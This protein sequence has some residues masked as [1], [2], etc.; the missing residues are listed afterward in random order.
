LPVDDGGFLL[1]GTAGGFY[2][3][4]FIDYQ[5][6]DAEILLIKVNSDGEEEWRQFYGGALHDMAYE[7]RKTNDGYYLI[8]STQS[9]GAGSFDM[10]LIKTNLAGEEEWIKAYGGEEF[11]YGI[12]LDVAPDGNLYLLG[13]TKSFGQS[14]SPD[15]YLIKA[16]SGGNEIWSQVIG[17]DDSDYGYSVKATPDNGCAL[18]GSTK[19]YGS[20]G[21]DVYFVKLDQSGNVEFFTNSTD[22][23]F[24]DFHV[25]F[26]PNPF[27]KNAY[28]EISPFDTGQGF[29]LSIIDSVGNLILEELPINS[30]KTKID[31]KNLS[32][33]MYF[34]IIT[35]KDDQLQPIKGKFVVN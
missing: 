21:K 22:T 11:E 23:V 4:T 34:Y 15:I 10:C 26:Y 33:G 13:T 27:D 12:S 20:G 19:S 31:A 2:N 29:R 32:S 24:S 16:D 9:Y 25:S 1:L 3:I 14:G 5:N 28:I 30:Y 17:G 35:S 6:S 18:A 7:I 8:G